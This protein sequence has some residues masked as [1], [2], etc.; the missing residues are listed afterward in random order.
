MPFLIRPFLLR[1][2]HFTSK[3][4]LLYG[5]A[6]EDAIG[7]V[8]KS[9]KHIFYSLFSLLQIRT[10]DY[11]TNSHVKYELVLT[12]SLIWFRQVVLGTPNVYHLYLSSAAS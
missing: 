12:A 3:R 7:F 1:D 5:N 4:V 8:S 11:T 10:L 9:D 6:L 2:V